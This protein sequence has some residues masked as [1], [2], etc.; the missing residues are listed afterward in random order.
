MLRKSCTSVST[1]CGILSHLV[2]HALSGLPPYSTV[3]PAYCTACD[4]LCVV[5]CM[6]QTRLIDSMCESTSRNPGWCFP[7]QTQ[8]ACMQARRIWEAVL[9]A[10]PKV[11]TDEGLATLAQLVGTWLLSSQ[12]GQSAS[13]RHALTCILSVRHHKSAALLVLQGSWHYGV[14][15]DSP[16]ERGRQVMLAASLAAAPDH[17]SCISVVG[18]RQCIAVACEQRC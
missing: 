8:A 1:R 7:I 16:H 12:F 18:S 11:R 15:C 9:Y 4:V 14:C 6:H 3:Q 13:G 2:M 5:K 10:Q 17:H